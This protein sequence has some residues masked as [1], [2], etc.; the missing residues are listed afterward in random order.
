VDPPTRYQVAEAL[1]HVHSRGVCHRDI[2]P[3]NLLLA[4]RTEGA[5]V[6][7]CDF[8]CAEFLSESGQAELKGR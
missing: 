4:D 7:L 5:P 6:R 8:G 3:E 1:Q 2:K